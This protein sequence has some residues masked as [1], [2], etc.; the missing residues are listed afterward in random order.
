MAMNCGS[1]SA[2]CLRG[3]AAVLLVAAV[4]A[5]G[6]MT[7]AATPGATTNP[8]LP[9]FEVATIKP[10]MGG[11]AGFVTTSGGRMKCAFCN[12]DMLLFYA[13][14]VQPYQIVGAPEWGHHA[15]GYSIDAIPPDSSELRNLKLSSPTSALT[16][17]QREMLKSLLMERFQLKFHRESEI[18]AVYVLTRGNGE[19]KLHAPKDKDSSPAVWMSNDGLTGQNASMPMLVV[20]L[21]GILQRPVL[22]ESGLSG[23]FDFKS[24]L[25]GVDPKAEYQDI[26][27]SILTSVQ[28]MGLK[29][30]AS[31]GPVETI[32]ID[33]IERPS[34]N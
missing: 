11:V 21:S 16:N 23:S 13:F 20:R 2:V 14:D 32:V 27:A 34:P 26:V 25:F 31:K 8:M 12:L 9:S 3:L 10:A 29:L 18:G 1:T 22:D 17:E 4:S 5:Q 7:P 28:E 6:Q 19:L 30:K 24:A 33:H 15:D